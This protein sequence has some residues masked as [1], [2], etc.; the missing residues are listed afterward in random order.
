MRLW[1]I[2]PKIVYD[3][4]KKDKVYHCDHTNPKCS[5]NDSDGNIAEEFILAYDFIAEQMKKRIGNPPKG[6]KYPIWLWYMDEPGKNKRPDLRKHGKYS[7][8]PYVMLE[9][10]VPDEEVLLSDFDDYH[11]ILNDWPIFT[12]Y[13]EYEQDII[14]EWF[15][16]L[17]KEEQNKYKRKSWEDIFNFDADPLD[18]DNYMGKK[19]A[20]NRCIQATIWELRKEEIIKVWRYY[21]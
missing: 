18:V 16:S 8:K 7:D 10:E 4:L 6:I 5:V 14:Y 15:E 3:I 11:C 17:S 20:N 2:Q 1:T 21:K 19:E 12:C 13:N 9:V